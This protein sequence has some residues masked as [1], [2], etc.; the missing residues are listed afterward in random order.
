MTPTNLRRTLDKLGFSQ[1]YAAKILGV[2]GR[3]VRRWLQPRKQNG[4]RE[5]PT[6]YGTV[7]QLLV[8]K[9]ITVK[10]LEDCL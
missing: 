9:K 10:D 3:A 2:K 4:F 7:L 1:L 5:I 8:K 6:I